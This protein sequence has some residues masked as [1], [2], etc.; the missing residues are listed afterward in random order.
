MTSTFRYRHPSF[1]RRALQTA[2][3]FKL[4]VVIVVALLGAA[5]IAE[6]NAVSSHG[7]QI[8]A[9]QKEITAARRDYEQLEIQV[10]TSQSMSVLEARIQSLQLVPTEHPVYIT[11]PSGAVALR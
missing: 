9:L 11:I 8:K 2:Y 6:A 7:M 3:R 4:F 1:L 10:A 5:Y